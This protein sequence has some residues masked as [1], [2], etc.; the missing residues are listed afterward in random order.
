MMM[1]GTKS[2]ENTLTNLNAK[3]G[4][5]RVNNDLREGENEDGNHDQWNQSFNQEEDRVKRDDPN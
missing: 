5:Q 4:A 2:L 3:K 1:L